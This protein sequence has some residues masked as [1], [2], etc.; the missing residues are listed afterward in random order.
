MKKYFFYL[1]ALVFI[2]S[3]DGEKPN[4]KTDTDS[5][6]V[7]A[8]TLTR[9]T[10]IVEESD[11]AE[12]ANYRA[13]E[14]R[15][16]NW[17]VDIPVGYA[18]HVDKL[19]GLSKVKQEGDEMDYSIDYLTATDLKK[20][21]TYELIYYFLNY[22]CSFSQNCGFDD[23]EDS[24]NTPKIL[25][26][27]EDSYGTADNSMLQDKALDLNRDSVIILMKAFIGKHLGKTDPMYMIILRDLKA[28][29]CIP[30]VVK[31]ASSKCLANFTFLVNYLASVEYEPFT[32]SEVG[33]TMFGEDRYTYGARVV[34]N[35]ENMKFIKDVA[36]KYYN[37]RKNY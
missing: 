37:E 4:E 24:T 26:Y 10:L 29:E 19:V 31:A 12:I 27:Y 17:A 36:M 34:A 33:R 5:T 2:A 18:K 22:P 9:D 28:F 30:I 13:S 11:S 21:N 25:A 8:D 1:A 15:W 6:A 14:K 7:T 20:L 32:D 3:C 23:F 35:A 16:A